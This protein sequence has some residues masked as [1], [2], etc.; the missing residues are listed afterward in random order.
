MDKK[1]IQIQLK[2]PVFQS[3]NV[4]FAG[5]LKTELL[6]DEFFSTYFVALSNRCD[7]FKTN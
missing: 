1:T 6:F 7:T 4:N 2:K 3:I 5:D